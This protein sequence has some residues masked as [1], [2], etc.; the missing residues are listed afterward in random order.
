MK[1]GVEFPKDFDVTVKLV[2]KYLMRFFCHVYN[3]LF[4]QVLH[5]HIEAHLNTLFAHFICFSIEFDLLEK[6]ELAPLA[7]LLQEWEALSIIPAG[8]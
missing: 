4:E 8:K 7:D 2:F 5:L 6:K 1:T 3:Y